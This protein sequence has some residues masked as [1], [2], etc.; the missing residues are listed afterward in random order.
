MDFQQIAKLAD[1]S[2]PSVKALLNQVWMPGDWFHL[3]DEVVSHYAH[4][5]AVCRL[6][7]DR[8]DG[9]V[10]RIIEVGTRA[11]Y[12]AAVFRQAAPFSRMLCIDGGL[13]DDS[14]RCLAHAERVFGLAD[15]DAQLVVVDTRDVRSL[16]I[17]AFAH[18]DGDHSFTGALRDLRLCSR[19]PVILLDDVCNP[20]VDRALRA[21]V[22]SS[23]RT[24]SVYHDGLRKAAVIE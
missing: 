5:A 3:T 20:N 10:L 2:A 1:A 13:D 19:C 7:A 8:V 11:G 16:P 21:F 14:G 12:S 6:A 15:V 4:K 22:D 23:G 24:F 18:V 9:G 17:A